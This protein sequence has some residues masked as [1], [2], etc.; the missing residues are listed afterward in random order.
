MRIAILTSGILPV[1]AVGG[2]AVEN[3]VDF[4]LEYNDIHKLHDIT[5]YS[6]WHPDVEQHPALQS[7]VNHYQYIKVD[8]PLAKI[9]KKLFH[10]TH[11]NDEYYH[12]AIEYYFHEALRRLRKEHYDAIILENRPGYAIKLADK[13]NAAL[14]VHLHNDSLNKNTYRSQEIYRPVTRI[15]TVSDYIANCV[16]SINPEDTKCQTVHNGIDM[17]AFANL[18]SDAHDRPSAFTLIFCGRMV[19]EKGIAELIEALNILYNRRPS[20][21]LDINLMVLGSSFYGNANKESDFIK[22]LKRTAEPIKQHIQ[23]TG[24]VPYDLVPSYL[25]LADVAVVP[26]LWDDPFPT[27]ILEAQA[28]GLPIITTMRG[29]IP[30]QVTGDNAL[31]L[32][33]DAHFT[34]RLADAILYLYEHPEKREEMSKAGLERSKQFSK[35]TYARNFFEALSTINV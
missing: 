10:Y 5:V 20:A 24:F 31:M 22:Q 29:G 25:R 16:R 14:V 33:T 8:T 35:E 18:S 2:G 12:Y 3:L 4:Y 30:E 15:I 28:M 11:Q 19:P 9:R 34:E 26:S 1:P 23:F 7:A 13:T 6:I 17:K 21:D 32:P 27:T